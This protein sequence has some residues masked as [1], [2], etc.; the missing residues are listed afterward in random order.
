M[1]L[2]M[3]LL[4]DLPIALAWLLS[5]GCCGKLCPLP[6]AYAN[7]LNTISE[8][9]ERAVFCMQSRG[10]NERFGTVTYTAWR[11]VAFF[12]RGR[13]CSSNCCLLFPCYQDLQGCDATLDANDRDTYELYYPKFCEKHSSDMDSEGCQ[14]AY[15]L[16][17]VY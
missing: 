11:D 7:E 8:N 16:K 2:L 5:G 15:E 6:C 12:G 1:A 14:R 9:D 17:P 13:P 10:R 3:G 4:T